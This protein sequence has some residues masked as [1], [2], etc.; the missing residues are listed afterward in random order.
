MAVLEERPLRAKFYPSHP[1]PRQILKRLLAIEKKLSALA[2]LPPKPLTYT[3]FTCLAIPFSTQ[4]KPV[5]SRALRE[6]LVKVIRNLK[7]TQTSGR[8]VESIN[9]ARSSRAGKVLAARK[10]ES[11]DILNTADIN[12][13]KSLCEQEEGWTK[14]IAKKSKVKGRRFTVMI[15]AMKTNRIETINKEKALAE[16]QAQ[17]PQLMDKVKFLKLTWQ[18][19]TLKASRLHGP[20]LVDVGTQ[21]EANTLV[22]DGFLHNY[23]LKNCELFHSE[24]IMTQ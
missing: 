19:K 17:N 8:L 15:H 13:T 20:L 22:Q 21:E 11:R 14:V 1:C 24:C 7:P 3:D 16:L 6:V 5:P 2:A 10:L 4:E 18:Q 9:A 23:E 12:E